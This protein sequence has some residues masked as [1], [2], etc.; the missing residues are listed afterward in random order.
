MFKRMY[1][2][3]KPNL[4]LLDRLRSILPKATLIT[5]S[6]FWCPDCKRNV[7]RMARIAELLPEWTFEVLNRDTDVIPEELGF[8][9][10]IPTFILRNSASAEIGRIIENPKFESL[11]EDMLRIAE[12]KY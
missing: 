6:T 4:E 3:Y 2:I 9:K 1:D 5:V 12:G 11:E 10:I 8:V 7:G